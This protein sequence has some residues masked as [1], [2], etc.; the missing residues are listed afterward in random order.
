MGVSIPFSRQPYIYVPGSVLY[1][2]FHEQ[3][4][5]RHVLSLSLCERSQGR[6]VVLSA[7]FLADDS[8]LQVAVYLLSYGKVQT[9][10]PLLD[11]ARD[12]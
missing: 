12:P 6:G 8:L 11:S 3:M 9:E 10:E 7:R 1:V 4:E 2:S 5:R